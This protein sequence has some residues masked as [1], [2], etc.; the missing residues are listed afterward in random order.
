MSEWKR[1]SRE[2]SYEGLPSDMKVEIQKHVELY[3]L[4]NILS[5]TVMCIQT[6][7]EK[8]KKGLFGSA[9]TVQMGAVVTPHWLLWVV[10]GTKTSTTAL[11]A[12]LTDIVVQDYANTQFAK[13]IPDSGLEV[14]GKFTDVAENGSAF[15]GL[16]ENAAGK[17]F[18]ETVITA[19]QNAKKQKQA[20]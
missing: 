12:L 13:M 14:T 8:P 9:E 15:L 20:S 7:S 2:L 11:S 6:D 18:K 4:G 19:V 1:S 17:K 10:N 5:D 3:N 16:E